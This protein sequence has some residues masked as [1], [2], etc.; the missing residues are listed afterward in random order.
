MEFRIIGQFRVVRVRIHERFVVPHHEPRLG[1]RVRVGDGLCG[2]VPLLQLVEV[3]HRVGQQTA[4]GG[5]VGLRQRTCRRRLVRRSGGVG[6]HVGLE[7][8]QGPWRAVVFAQRRRTRIFRGQVISGYIVWVVGNIMIVYAAVSVQDTLIPRIVKTAGNCVVKGVVCAH[9]TSLILPDR[10]TI[11]NVNIV[12]VIGKR[13]TSHH[14]PT[15]EARIAS[16]YTNAIR[17]L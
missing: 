9:I 16:H 7:T 17:Q 6:V 14:K 3:Q 8:G 4:H 13:A 10:C 11:A 5:V 1:Q 2:G 12:P 15:A